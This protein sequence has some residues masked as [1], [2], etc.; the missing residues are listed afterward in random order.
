MIFTPELKQILLDAPDGQLDECMKPLIEKWDNPPKAIQLLE[1][2]D[3]I[4]HA[5]LA[6]GF[7]LSLLQM[8]LHEA[9]AAEGTTHEELVKLATWRER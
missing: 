5:A 8:M 4:I 3:H 7:I 2:V 9:I 1:V 6:S